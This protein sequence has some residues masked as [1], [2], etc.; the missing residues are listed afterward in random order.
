M[1]LMICLRG[2]PE[3]LQYLP[4]IS[5]L[6]AGIE[7]G[8]Y[9]LVGVQSA[10]AWETRFQHHQ[11][12]RAQ[13]QGRLALHGPFLGMEYAHQ[14][15]LIRAVVK[16][17]LDMT[18]ETARN[19]EVQRVILH[20]GYQRD[21]ELYKLQDTWLESN[22]DFWQREIMRWAEAG[23]EIVLENDTEQAPDLLVRLVEAVN[24]PSLGLC[25]DIGHQHMFSELNAL[26]WVRRM[27]GRLY[28]IHLHNN[29]RTR[30]SHGSLGS[31]TIQFVP[32]FEV[33]RKQAPQATLSL[34]VEDKMELK[35]RDL[36]YLVDYFS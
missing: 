14:D 36:R 13:F 23:I 20:S 35:M 11:A 28:H 31:G 8:S 24:H 17:L 15:H 21:F 29:D 27:E 30:D 18:F 19:L 33:L 22:I 2:E 5:E 6:G 3:Q 7:L 32:F 34:E 1:H 9:G 25:L 26:E 4:E 10:Q 12:I 16:Q